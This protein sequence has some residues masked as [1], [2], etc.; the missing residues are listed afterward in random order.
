MAPALTAY[1]QEETA[2]LN[3]NNALANQILKYQA[4]E[5]EKRALEEQ[6]AWQRQLA[7]AQ[8]GES[9][10]YHDLMTQK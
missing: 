8:L 4:H 9:R 7:E 1:D 3:E 10:R 6:R 2:A 5:Q